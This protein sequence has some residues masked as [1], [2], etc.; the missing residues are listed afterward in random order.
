[1]TENR[2]YTEIINI[3]ENK[4]WDKLKYSLADMHAAEIVDII[5]ILDNDKNKSILFRLL[6]TEKAADVFSELDSNEQEALI[7]SMNDNQLMELIHEMS[8]DDRTSL[9]EELPSDIT[10]NI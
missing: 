7:S 1:M 10:K 5:R 4:R 9:F 2:E 8:P 6:S 3:I